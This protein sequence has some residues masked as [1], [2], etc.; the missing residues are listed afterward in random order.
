MKVSI[1]W[2]KDYS[3]I[4]IDTKELAHVMSMTGSKVEGIE[5]KGNDIKNVVVG[6]ILE[7]EK[8][9]NADKLVVTK[10][11][12]GDE[13]IQIVTGA[14]NIKVGDIIPVAKNG[15]ELPNN[16]KIT[17]GLLRGIE[18]NGMMCS[19]PELALKIED[20]P[21]QIED[22]IM[23]LNKEYEK[24]ISKDIVEVLDLKKEVI[25]KN[26]FQIIRNLVVIVIYPCSPPL[27]LYPRKR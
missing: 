17:K 24:Y 3:E 7:I 6:K 14:T 23:I 25:S 16:V 21:G 20:Y 11:D 27:P 2:L 9:P 13:I 22:G 26:I 18:S 10:V 8:H 19:V 1:N 5:E 12:I 4:D 15:S